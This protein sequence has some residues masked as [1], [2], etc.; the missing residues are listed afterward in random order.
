MTNGN[1]RIT[2]NAV[3]VQQQKKKTSPKKGK[4]NNNKKKNSQTIKADFP[5]GP[6]SDLAGNDP[7][8]NFSA[9]STNSDLVACSNDDLGMVQTYVDPCSTNRIGL[10]VKKIKDDAFRVS[11]AAEYRF[12]GPVAAP[13]RSLSTINA[14]G[15]LV[16]N[17]SWLILQTSLLRAP[18]ILLVNLRSREF[19]SEIMKGFSR[20]W[21][22]LP[23]RD[24]AFWP[25]YY[26]FISGEEALDD[27]G[28]VILENYFTVLTPTALKALTEPDANGVSS[29]LTQFRTV[30]QGID[31]HF[32]VPSAI[33]Q[34][35]AIMSRFP[36]TISSITPMRNHVRGFD[37]YYLVASQPGAIQGFVSVSFR[38]PTNEV[39]PPLSDFELINVS[40]PNLPG[41]TPAFI[42]TVNVR[43]S[44]GSFTIDVGD[45]CGYSRLLGT[46][47][48]VLRNLSTGQTLSV[49]AIG[50]LA[51]STRLYVRLPL[52]DTDSV[53]IN[54]MSDVMT[55]ITLPPLTQADCGQMNVATSVFD[56]KDYGGI[57]LPN[58][59]WKPI[60]EPQQSTEYR[61]VI[62]LLPGLSLEE[63]DYPGLGWYDSYDKNF[64]I[65]V[66]NILGMSQAAIPQLHAV[67]ADEQMPASDSFI[68]AYTTDCAGANIPMLDAARTIV[69]EFTVGFP[70]G[71]SGLSDVI[72]M[73][74][75]VMGNMPVAEAHTL[76]VANK[77]KKVID[78]VKTGH[79]K[80]AQ[81]KRAMRP[82][83][84]S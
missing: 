45:S 26:Q 53:P 24:S 66:I 34:A 43:N 74:S 61:K 55:T 8:T 58:Q 81:F 30:G 71:F 6:S 13:T 83:W 27:T 33:D 70:H 47:T 72:G 67:R 79:S 77:V 73:V 69:D 18:F 10:E 7:I 31:L 62:F 49:L 48:I 19:G 35:A 2:A 11:A 29:I 4:K 5:A 20:A 78:M 60:F 14:E 17:M 12:I 21:A 46:N 32:N 22:T 28:V 80:L 68:G 3:N 38:S 41:S 36:S 44:T 16:N 56:L 1:V 9:F 50:S 23:D 76:N 25:N 65:A 40:V 57:Y 52:T 63:V 84:R 51:Q 42:S 15:Q 75:E 59:I 39:I 37:E 64:G 54:E 82:N